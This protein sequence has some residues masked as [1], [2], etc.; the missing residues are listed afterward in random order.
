MAVPRIPMATPTAIQQRI[1]SGQVFNGTLPVADPT[2][3]MSNAMYKFAAANAGG[4]FFW[5]TREPMLVNQML[6][7]LGGSA[8]ITVSL[9][10]ID[11]LTVDNAAPTILAGEEMIIEAVTAVTKLSLNETNFKVTLLPFQAIKLVT[12]NSGAAQI[13]QLMGRLDRVRSS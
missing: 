6:V 9:V 3:D 13:A 7:S 1:N 2:I 11:P 5:N 10:N 12:T 8:N 4:L